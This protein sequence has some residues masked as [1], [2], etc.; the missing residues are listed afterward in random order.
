MIPCQGEWK[1]QKSVPA[2]QTNNKKKKKK[3]EKNNAND[4]AN[5]R[6]GM[7][8]KGRSPVEASG[9]GEREVQPLECCTTETERI[10]SGAPVTVGPRG[11]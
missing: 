5:K 10:S 8:R 7:R 1:R 3:K 11:N 2:S 4:D 9:D 6:G